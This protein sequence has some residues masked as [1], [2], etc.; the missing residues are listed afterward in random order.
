MRVIENASIFHAYSLLQN[1]TFKQKTKLYL[2]ETFVVH[3][4]K[5]IG[6]TL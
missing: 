1:N 6:L 4:V 2:D 3:C 5:N